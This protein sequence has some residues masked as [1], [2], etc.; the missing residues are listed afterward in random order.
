MRNERFSCIKCGNGFIDKG[1][2]NSH[3]EKEH[4]QLYVFWLLNVEMCALT[5]VV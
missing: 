2:S 4:A 3:M 5:R 1:D